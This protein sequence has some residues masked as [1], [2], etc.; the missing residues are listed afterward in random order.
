MGKSDFSQLM[1]ISNKKIIK[2]V[3]TSALFNDMRCLSSRARLDLKLRLTSVWSCRNTSTTRSRTERVTRWSSTGRC[4]AGS[5]EKKEKRKEKGTKMHK[6]DLDELW[7]AGGVAGLALLQ[8][9]AGMNSV[10]TSRC[11]YN[12]PLLY[13]HEW[14]NWL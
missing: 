11:Q 12:V 1:C 7:L 4:V 14:R 10:F 6:V 5:G 8:L 13:S 3:K 2:Q 9:C